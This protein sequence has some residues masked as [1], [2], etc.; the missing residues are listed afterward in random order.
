MICCGYLGS[1]YVDLSPILK[2]Y[3]THGRH[4]ADLHQQ[5]VCGIFEGIVPRRQLGP[6][7]A[8]IL[9][10]LQLSFILFLIFDLVA[11]VYIVCFLPCFEFASGTSRLS[12]HLLVRPNLH[13]PAPFSGV[14]DFLAM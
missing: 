12:G 13:H 2:R 3:A 1:A 11:Y 10:S 9:C 14:L 6:D 4:L 5:G 8:P 7:V